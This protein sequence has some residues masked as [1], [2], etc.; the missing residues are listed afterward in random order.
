M[1]TIG[2]RLD[3]EVANTIKWI[4]ES[5]PRGTVATYGQIAEIAGMPRRARFVARILSTSDDI[6]RLPW[7]RVIRADG[8]IAPRPSADEQIKRLQAECI[9][10]VDGRVNL[11]RFQWS[12]L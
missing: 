11:S 9:E 12:D 1:L 2:D 4:I 6:D 7:H 3:D 5:I 10:V 8:R